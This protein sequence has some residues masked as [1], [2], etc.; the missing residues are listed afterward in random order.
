ML[1]F[2]LL[3]TCVFVLFFSYDSNVSA[4]KNHKIGSYAWLENIGW[5]SLNCYNDGIA[6]KCL[7]SDYGVDYDTN[8]NKMSGFGWSEYGGWLC[9]GESCGQ[10]GLNVAPDKAAPVIRITDNGLLTGWAN[11]T[12]LGE[13]GWLK[14]QGPKLTSA[15]GAKYACKNCVKLKGESSER[16]GFCFGDN[17]L[18]LNGSGSICEQ[19]QSCQVATCQ[20]CSSCYQYGVG[21][22]YSNNTLIGWGANYDATEV[23][24]G[25]LHFR[26]PFD[27]NV[28]APYLETIGGDIYGGAGIGSLFQGIAPIGKYNATYMIQSNGDI[29][30]F[31]SACED[32]GYCEVAGWVSDQMDQFNLPK[33]ENNYRGSLGV[34][35]IKGLL[36]GQHG[37][38]GKIYTSSQIGNDLKGR[39]YY[40]NDDLHVDAV[41]TFLNS[42]G[43][44]KASGT[45]VVR[46]DLYLEADS[47]YQ[48]G[49]TKTLKNLASVGW[50]VLKKENGDGGNVYID[51]AVENLVG[52]FFAEGKIF[53]GTTGDSATEKGLRVDGLMVASEFSFDRQFTDWETKEPAERIVYDGRVIANTPPGFADLTKALP[54]WK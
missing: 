6:N 36:A 3:V 38:V 19:C 18:N 29:I 46:G 20:S 45:I 51:P 49:T 25:W 23:G 10:A 48:A 2:S 54:V 11:W 37:K 43:A 8:T 24:F 31:A 39:V 47:F 33:Q 1:I 16:C 7:Q 15:S 14:L 30:H 32:E 22:D 27:S 34:L 44:T 26:L 52:S 50:I 13:A 4:S 41:K 53:T 17:S 28:N 5:V 12:T 35:D 9:F 40:A 42:S 21:L